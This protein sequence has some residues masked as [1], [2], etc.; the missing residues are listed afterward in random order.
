MKREILGASSLWGSKV[1][2][3]MTSLAEEIGQENDL[4]GAEQM[5]DDSPSSLSLSV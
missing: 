4:N 1:D 3:M 5:E 2:E